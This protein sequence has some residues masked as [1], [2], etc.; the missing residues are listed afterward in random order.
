MSTTVSKTLTYYPIQSYLLKRKI[1]YASAT[2]VF[3]GN[4]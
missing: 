2:D 1:Y 3:Q 4:L